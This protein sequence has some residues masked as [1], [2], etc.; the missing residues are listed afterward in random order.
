LGTLLACPPHGGAATRAPSGFASAGGAGPAV[1]PGKPN[2][3]L[4]F[5][6]D[7]GYEDVGCYGA[8]GIKTPHLDRLASEGVRFTDFY[9]GAPLCSA[10]RAA[11]MTGR[12]YPRTG[13]PDVLRQG[14]GAMR[15]SEVTLAEVLKPA[16]Y[17][18]ACFG[19]WHLGFAPEWLPTRQGFDEFFGLPFSNNMSVNYERLTELYR[20]HFGLKVP[21]A[22]LHGKEEVS[23]AP[24]YRNDEVVEWPVVQET[25]TRRFT[26]AAQR[27]IREHRREP[28]FVYLAH[29]MPHRPLAASE[30]FQGSSERGVYGDALQELDWSVGQ[31]LSTLREL[32]LAENTLV[33]YLSDNGPRPP[34]SAEPLRGLKA[35]TW[36]GGVRVPCIMRW[37]ARIPAGTVCGEV[38]ASMDLMPTF[39]EI[40][41]AQAP[42][43]RIIDGR[44]ILPLMTGRPDAASP[45]QRLFY[46]YQLEAEAVREGP[47]KYRRAR[48]R[49]RASDGGWAYE[50]QEPELYNL[51]E[52]IGE[53]RNLAADHPERVQAMAE[54]L[55]A[56]NE[57]LDSQ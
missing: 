9:V 15:L 34:G 33:V 10:S 47:W 29:P 39:A 38:A 28:F 40:A 22:I 51:A 19:K 45:H 35:Q 36:E 14:G 21:D 46:C 55:A 5:T 12:Y 30:A 3:V 48:K 11:L 44:S 2:I 1:A 53:S 17:A 57:Q 54:A 27:F 43:D 23:G 52:D 8:S 37:P 26:E 31:I 18:T 16:G 49:V 41:G 25:M 7:Q 6:D 56:F 4:V 20:D 42:R 13:V 24:L 50:L 32:G